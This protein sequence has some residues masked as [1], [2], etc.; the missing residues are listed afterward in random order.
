MNDEK[1]LDKLVD[2]CLKEMDKCLLAE[3][4]KEYNT[5]V[6]CVNNKYIYFINADK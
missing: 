1:H 6:M 5:M 4:Y 3:T 2:M